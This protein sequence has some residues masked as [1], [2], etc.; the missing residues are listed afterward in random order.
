MPT[1]GSIGSWM[2]STAGMQSTP[3]MM[4][5]IVPCTTRREMMNK[6]ENKTDKGT[7]PYRGDYWI[8]YKFLE[9]PGDLYDFRRELDSP[10]TAGTVVW[11]SCDEGLAERFGI[12]GYKGSLPYLLD[13]EQFESMRND[14]LRGLGEK[15][16]LL[17]LLVGV[18]DFRK[19]GMKGMV[20]G[21]G[22][23]AILNHLVERLEVGFGWTDREEMILETARYSRRVFGR[24]TAV[25][26]LESYL[27]DFGFHEE[28]VLA[29]IAMR[30]DAVFMDQSLEPLRGILDYLSRFATEL[31]TSGRDEWIS[32]IHYAILQYEGQGEAVREA[33]FADR[34]KERISSSHYLRLFD[35]IGEQGTLELDDLLK[36]GTAPPD[37]MPGF[38]VIGFSPKLEFPAYAVTRHLYPEM[39]QPG[40]LRYVYHPGLA[41][42]CETF[43]V[44]EQD[45]EFFLDDVID[46]AER[47]FRNRP[48]GNF[49]TFLTSQRVLQNNPK[50]GGILMALASE[51]MSKRIGG[52]LES[53]K[54]R[55]CG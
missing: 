3:L 1:M 35:W 51:A 36:L 13:D 12:P 28:I 22:L 6:T 16:L 45:V 9:T 44:T 26:I 5:P 39:R 7:R 23:L 24:K 47:F 49:H 33:G 32:L 2:E 8:N 20:D 18:P 21:E 17:G 11:L 41:N 50:A 37:L 48:G 27:D 10:G 25:G 29:S 54:K 55:Y 4:R 53:I 43:G 31:K 46:Q 34:L 15:E 52:E 38:D 14:T 42:R 40:I 30:W 19:D